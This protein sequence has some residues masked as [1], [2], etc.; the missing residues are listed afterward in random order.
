MLHVDKQTLISLVL[1]R[2]LAFVGPPSSAIL[3]SPAPPS[4]STP[5]T[6]YLP[7]PCTASCTCVCPFPV[8][9]FYFYTFFLGC[10]ASS[11]LWVGFVTGTAWARR[12]FTTTRVTAQV[13]SSQFSAAD[14]SGEAGRR[15]VDSFRPSFSSSPSSSVSDGVGVDVAAVAR[16]QLALV[17]SRK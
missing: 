5:V 12:R 4:S 6:V 8:E 1:T 3:S 17:R 16:A 7:E 2:L 15:D 13:S 9:H 14:Q 10:G 11:L